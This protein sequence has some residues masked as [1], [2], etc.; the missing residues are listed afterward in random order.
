MFAVWIAFSL[1]L[2][3][4]Y[5]P[6][7]ELATIAILLTGPTIGVIAFERFGM[8]RMVTRYIGAKGVKR[9]ASAL[10]LTVLIWAMAVL[11]LRDVAIFPRTALILFFMISL[12]LT[13]GVRAIA[14]R[15][16][17]STANNGLGTGLG[18]DA[19][20]QRAS[21]M[22]YGAGE[23]GNQLANELRTNKRLNPVGFFDDDASLWGQK[24]G[25]LKV[26]SP[27]ELE[28]VIKSNGVREVLLAMPAMTRH[29]RR[30]LLAKFTNTAVKVRSVPSFAEIASGAVCRGRVAPH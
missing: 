14:A 26:W 7:P 22:I 28:R 3:T 8:Y 29:Q 9:A 20:S 13:V 18:D 16:F 2:G 6:P 15:L 25:E 23:T 4:F 27:G 11:M 1:R 5:L 12:V 30:E 19:R 24:V 21:V 17:N 10:A